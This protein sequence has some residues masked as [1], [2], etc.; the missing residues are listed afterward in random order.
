MPIREN[1]VDLEVEQTIGKALKIASRVVCLTSEAS[2]GARLGGFD[3]G[4]T[5]ESADI[6][7]ADRLFNFWFKVY[8]VFFKPRHSIR[9]DARL[10]RGQRGERNEGQ[11]RLGRREGHRL[12]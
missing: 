6:K 4:N 5:N 11:Q 2:G 7:S 9:L 8:E 10:A 3:I 1:T 12:A